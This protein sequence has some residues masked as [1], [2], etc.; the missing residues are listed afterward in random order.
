MKCPMTFGGDRRSV[1][2]DECRSD[3]AWLI[4]NFEAPGTELACA[5]AVMA[6]SETDSMSLCP[7]NYM[8]GGDEA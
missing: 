7:A 4:F 8:K 3:C 2:T 6:S 1:S 5:V